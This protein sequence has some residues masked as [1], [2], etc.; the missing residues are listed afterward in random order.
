MN[1]VFAT[2]ALLGLLVALVGLV[3]QVGHSDFEAWAPVL[4]VVLVERAVRVLPSDERDVRREEWFTEIG[5][6]PA[7]A[8]ISKVVAAWDLRRA[9]RNL[10]RGKAIRND[11]PLPFWTRSVRSVKAHRADRQLQEWLSGDRQNVDRL[12]S[13]L[14]CL[15]IYE[16]YEQS[17]GATARALNCNGNTIYAGIHRLERLLEEDLLC[18]DTRKSLTRL[19]YDI[20]NG[21]RPLIWSVFDDH[22]GRLTKVDRRQVINAIVNG[23]S[24]YSSEKRR[25]RLPTRVASGLQMRLFH[26]DPAE[27]QLSPKL[28]PMDSA[29]FDA[30]RVDQTTAAG[31]VR[32]I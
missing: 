28:E 10:A 26:I 16:Q 3:W 18:Q 27:N 23:Y 9:A 22:A 1:I 21:V 14:F 20:A 29:V 17:V 8:V 2:I 19:G 13:Y 15:V 7:G 31:E 4:V 12:L 5:D 24:G 32:P 30:K 11:S 6:L 25:I